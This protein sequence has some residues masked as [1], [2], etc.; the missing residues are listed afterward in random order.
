MRKRLFLTAALAALTLALAFCA[1]CVN[2]EESS[3]IPLSEVIASGD[4]YSYKIELKPVL[5]CSGQGEFT[6]AQGAASDGKYVYFVFRQS[7]NG[8]C[9]VRKCSLKTKKIVKTS[10]PIYLFH[11]NDMTYD[12]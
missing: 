4:K 11:G 6:S 9:I 5:T 7:E 2:T 8:D 12:S 3:G 1:G 10:A